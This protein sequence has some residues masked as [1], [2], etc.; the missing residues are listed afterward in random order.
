MVKTIKSFSLIIASLIFISGA[1]YA[2]EVYIPAARADKRTVNF[3]VSKGEGIKKIGE[4]LAKAGLIRS[5]FFFEVYVW[6][7]GI[8]SRFQ[9]GEYALSPSMNI[10]ETA[11]VLVRGEALSNED[12]VKIIEGW[13][14]REIARYLE[15]QGRANSDVFLKAVGSSSS[16]VWNKKYDFLA[17][18][19]AVAGLEGY[20]FPDTYRVF[21]DATV[22]D[23]VGKMLDNFGKKLTPQMRKDI[24][25]QHKSVYEIVT[26]ASLIE[27]EVKTPEDMAVVSGIFW[28][29][30]EAG[31]A[32][33]SDATL[34]YVLDDN[35]ASHTSRDLDLDSPY[36]SYKHPG[37]P[38][39]PISNPGL[40]AL[41]AAIYPK[42]TDFNYFLT[43]KTGRT[44]F[45]KTFEEHK[46]NKA[47]FLK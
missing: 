1:V 13:N 42:F 10:E 11:G 32:L 45:S 16:R 38:P 12:T 2:G 44:V 3:T 47:Q 14:S 8:E 7:K 34:S 31:Q 33:Q 21:K 29:R 39:T 6:Q 36:N 17:D 15:A 22:E 41:K 40:N 19:P 46:R 28:K 37:L 26:M 25:A 43:D 9:A 18:R 30:L 5:E 24:S 4:K 27:K 35:V 23:I 20:L